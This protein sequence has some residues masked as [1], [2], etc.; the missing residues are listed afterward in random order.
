LRSLVWFR[1]DLRVADN[2]ALY[3][4]AAA[5]EVVGVFL[6]A[7][8][9]WRQ[10]DVGDNRLAFLLDCLEGLSE[11]LAALNIP[12]CIVRSPRFADAP[13]SLLRLATDVGARRLAFNRE[14]PLNEQVR[15]SRVTRACEEAGIETWSF[16]GGVILPP[17]RVLTNNDEPYTVYT[18]FR[19]RWASTLSRGEREPLPAPER[20]SPLSDVAGTPVQQSI[21]G[22]AIDR[23]RDRWPGGEREAE[24]R[25]LRFLEERAEAYEE[26]RDLPAR[27]GT[28]ELSPY[29]S[30]GAISA[31]RCLAAA[32][33]AN[34]GRLN[35]GQ[36]GL[37]TWISELIWR[38]FYRHVVAQF[39]HVSRGESFK[40]DMDALPWRR[41]P[42]ELAAWQEGRTG[43]PLVDAAMRQLNATGWMHNRLRMLTAMFLTKHLLIDWREGERYFMEQ[44]V[45]GDFAANNGGWQ[46]SAATGTDAAPYFRIFNP[47][48]QAE[49]FDAGGDFIRSYLPEL[50]GLEA[51]ALFQPGANGYAEPLVE[52]RAARERALAFFKGA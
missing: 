51:P 41:A 52:H 34:R 7:T 45:D 13:R 38:D 14:Y 25:L 49:R 15:D 40:R 36:K 44:L 18:P 26:Q 3:E 35:G 8:R 39:P 50:A 10:H 22:V 23:V 11:D 31:R 42:A 19:K 46:W 5:G 29:L 43:Y 20:Q 47:T 28:S 30:V 4:A 6:L 27:A 16:D 37:D 17:G 32:L 48:T 2:P 12:L 1:N 21:D 33:G 24:R 9:Q